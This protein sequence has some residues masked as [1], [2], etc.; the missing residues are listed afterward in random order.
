MEVLSLFLTCA[1][2]HSAGCF[3]F[4]RLDRRPNYTLG[5]LFALLMRNGCKRVDEAGR[6]ANHFRWAR[7]ALKYSCCLQSLS[8]RCIQVTER[9]LSNEDDCIP[10]VFRPQSS[11]C[12][13]SF[14]AQ[15]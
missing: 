11:S 7:F 12:F 10:K 13:P 6:L 4:V 3:E 8:S 5:F 1:K 9:R 2:G 15:C 14:T